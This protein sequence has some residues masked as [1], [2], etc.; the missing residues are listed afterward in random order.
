MSI[1][2]R[3]ADWF[4]VSPGPPPM[5]PGLPALDIID[6]RSYVV[7]P[8]VVAVGEERWGHDTSESF[9]PDYLNYAV[10]SNNVYVCVTKRA[11]AISSL[12]IKLYKGTDRNKRKEVTTGGART[13]LDSVN[14]WMTFDR[15]LTITEQHLCL[16]GQAFWFLERGSS[17]RRPPTEIWPVRP[18]L[19]RIVPDAKDFI[20]GFLLY[21]ENGGEPIAYSPDEVIWFAYPHPKDPYAGLAPL[22]AAR[23]AADTASAA[24][25]SNKAIFQ[26]GARVGGVISPADNGQTITED[27]QKD[28]QREFN[29]A[30]GTKN[31]HLI[32]ILAYA[33][34]FQ[35]WNMTPKDAEF[36]GALDLTLEEIARAFGIAPDLLG[37]S[38]R[39]YQN[40]PEARYAFWAD[41]IMS[42]ARF[43]QN[44]ITE[45]L[46]PMFPGEAD[47]AEFDF[48]D[49]DALRENEDAKWARELGQITANA[50]TI[51]EWRKDQGLKAVPWGDDAWVQS[52][53]TPIGGPLA[54]DAEALAEEMAQLEQLAKV[55]IKELPSGQEPSD[56]DQEGQGGAE[57]AHRTRNIPYGSAEHE[58]LATR[59]E[60][61]TAPHETVIAET[62]AKLMRSQR[63]AI[64]VKLK[65]QDLRAYSG[66]Q[67]LAVK[68]LMESVFSLP[69]WIRQFR[70]AI[71]PVFTDIVEAVGNQALDDLATERGM[72]RADVVGIAAMFDV[73]DPNVV[74]FLIA[75]AQRFAREINE[76]TWDLLKTS[77][78]EGLDAGEGIDV[79]A[80]RVEKIMAERIRSSAEVIARTETTAAANGGTMLSWQQSGVVRGKRW[81]AAKDSRTR[82]THAAAHGQTVALDEDFRVGG[83]SGPGPGMMSKASESVNCR[84]FPGDTVVYAE[85]VHAGSM[86]WFEGNIVTLRFEDGRV[87]T[88]TPNHPLLTLNGWVAAGDLDV[89]R[90]LV[91]YRLSE[92]VAFDPHKDNR[93]AMFSE[94]FRS[95]TLAGYTR[96]I[97][98]S[99]DQ[100]H[101]DGMSGDVNVV[102]TNSKL[103]SRFDTALAQPVH[104]LTFAQANAPESGCTL[105]DRSVKGGVREA[106]ALVG[107]SLTHPNDHRLVPVSRVDARLIQTNPN[108]TATDT[109][110]GSERLRRLSGAVTTYDSGV[111]D[112]LAPLEI[113]PIRLGFAGVADVDASGNKTTVDGVV[114]NAKETTKFLARGTGFVLTNDVGVIENGSF[115]GSDLSAVGF[116]ERSTRDT[117]T[118]ERVVDGGSVAADILRDGVCRF[119][120]DI[121]LNKIVMVELGVFAGHVYNLHTDT[122]RY[123]ANGIV[124][125]NCSMTAVLDDEPLEPRAV[126]ILTEMAS[127]LGVQS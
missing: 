57:R 39:T 13:L 21:P 24:M 30:R 92:R 80:K 81:L 83:A 125:H 100:F 85:G 19:V 84:C 126:T 11:S 110:C 28:L 63:Q 94:V 41:T 37:G 50:I 26:N 101:G 36:L 88:V 18:D 33:V 61:R 66:D 119:P 14:P 59:F 1:I 43:I 75:Q 17:A 44:V 10:T 111:I 15:L 93:P 6:T 118:L 72:K 8:S 105:D 23:L 121:T 38:K 12:P 77:L 3:V 96:G 108:P 7:G 115:P 97:G 56:D 102:S 31:A 48:E 86:R 64:L 42:E 67:R 82:K 35:N 117:S 29:K 34:K 20:K 47:V 54:Q 89:G 22:A 99:V 2:Q 116:G 16:T 55:T 58:R 113:G 104:D 49:V 122:G 87:L 103:R 78:G 123:L 127:A 109:E 46:L 52:G 9:D 112:D 40:A 62:T 91:G 27:Q 70:E 98:G 107:V 74:R 79:L 69:R 95:L 32:A 51:N 73:S 45:R 114:G 4:A 5:Q 90:E 76:T 53:L 25:Q 124:A 71:R 68:D 106:L 60:E 65:A 120:G